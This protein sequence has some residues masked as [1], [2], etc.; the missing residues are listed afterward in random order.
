MRDWAPSGAAKGIAKHAGIA[1]L[2]AI[3]FLG[4]FPISSAAQGLLPD[5]PGKDVFASVCTQCHGLESVITLRLGRQEWEG[6]VNDMISR[7]APAFGNDYEVIV[8]Y[9]AT[10]F[11]TN[12]KPPQSP[13]PESAS[14]SGDARASAAV[15]P[16][17]EIVES[18]CTECHSINN[19]TDSRRTAEEWR[20]TVHMMVNYGASL[21]DDEIDAVV[22]YLA[23][24]YG[25][26]SGAGT[27]GA[28]AERRPASGG[29]ERA[30]GLPDGPGKEVVASVCTQC[31]GLDNVTTLRLAPEE[32]EGLVNDMISRGAPAFGDQYQII[33]QYLIENFGKGR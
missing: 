16:G 7:G 31:H 14:V 12:S 24:N 19:V 2:F 18:T 6:L 11:G 30:G 17:R 9:L 33:T 32:W 29:D 28:G 1:S 5:G 22:D 10:N 3:L 21:L 23:A 25:P 4:V 27:R 26:S 8:N 15:G 20:E 13:M